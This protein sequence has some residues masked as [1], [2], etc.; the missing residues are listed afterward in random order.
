MFFFANKLVAKKESIVD[1]LGLGVNAISINSVKLEDENHSLMK[2]I[3][4]SKIVI[5]NYQP[6]KTGIITKESLHDLILSIKENGILQP[7]IVRPIG[8][9]QYELIAGERRY[10]SAI[11]ASLSEIPCVIKNVSKKDAFAI[12]LIE[13]I[14]REQLSLLEESE[15]LLK[16]KNEHFLSVDEVSKM[17]GKPRTTIANLIRVASL[18]CPEGKIMFEQGILDYGHI[19]SVLI[20]SHELQN[21]ILQ[22]VASNKLSVRKT[23]LLIRDKKYFQLLTKDVETNTEKSYVLKDDLKLISDKFSII[24]GRSAKIKTLKSGQVRVSIEFQDISKAYDYIKEKHQL[25]FIE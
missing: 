7:I 16:L 18:L 8:L 2:N 21:V 5:G 20:L 24:Y 17:I 6:R 15:A 13:N 25:D 1:I 9:E 3:Q 12:A 19:R 14:Q 10:R 4:S 22:H 11:E 23:E